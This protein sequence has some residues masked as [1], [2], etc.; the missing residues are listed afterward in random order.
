MWEKYQKVFVSVCERIGSLVG[1]RKPAKTANRLPG[2]YPEVFVEERSQSESIEILQESLSSSFSSPG[3]VL[4][5]ILAWTG[6]QPFLTKFLCDSVAKLAIIPEND[7][8]TQIA[9][10]VNREIF[11]NWRHRE[12]LRCHFQEIENRFVRASLQTQYHPLAALKLYRKLHTKPC[13]VNSCEDSRDGINFLLSSNLAVKS[14]SL[15]SIANP[16]YKQIFNLNWVEETKKTLKQQ[17]RICMATEKVFNREVFILIDTSGTMWDKDFTTGGK[18]RH[19]F[20]LEKVQGH[21]GELL[22]YEDPDDETKICDSV[23][24]YCFGAEEKRIKPYTI[25]ETAALKQVWKENTPN[26]GTIIAPIFKTALSQWS[27][28]RSVNNKNAFIIIYTDGILEDPDRFVDLIEN[29]CESIDSQDEIKILIVGMGAEIL[30][31]KQVEFYLGLDFGAQ[32]FKTRGG[33]DCNIVIFNL[34][35]EVDKMGGILEALSAQLSDNPREGIANW[36][37]DDYPT[38]YK[39]Y[40]G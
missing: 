9:L 36:I 22:N 11:Q 10:L 6:G 7:M 32:E 13:H 4:K 23:T 39:K 8:N 24:V 16:I 18:S 29:T 27:E 5:E 20:L 38:V 19:K 30:D 25:S 33:E 1:R 12:E 21:V 14:G 34:L 28:R 15:I 31:E 17:R 26:G 3:L 2:S 37:K 35:K 40:F